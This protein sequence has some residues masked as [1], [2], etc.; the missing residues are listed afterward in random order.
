MRERGA[1]GLTSAGV[2]PLETE[3]RTGTPASPATFHIKDAMTEQRS[4]NIK[5]SAAAARAQTPA[6]GTR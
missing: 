3:A 4:G 1:G 6:A 5:R 2:V